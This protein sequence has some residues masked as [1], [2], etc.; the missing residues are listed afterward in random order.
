MQANLQDQSSLLSLAEVDLALSRNRVSTKKLAESTEVDA[1]RGRL[2]GQSDRLIDAR[3][4]LSDLELQ[5]KRSETDLEL[6]EKRLNQDEERLSKAQNQK[7]AEGLQHEIQS[8]KLRKS[9][10]EDVEIGI[11]DELEKQKQL[12]QEI[13]NQKKLAE[14]E[15]EQT[16]LTQKNQEN[17]LG[18]QATELEAKRQQIVSSISPE[19][20][21]AYE[22]KAKRGT[23]FARLMGRDCGACNLSIMA[24]VLD[25]I[26]QLP[27]DQLPECP[28]CQAYLV[29]S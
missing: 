21:L 11:L 10:L 19:L 22:A 29:R 27:L 14:A 25:E 26:S 8:L 13:T 2:L 5:L 4:A 3:N 7:D 17:E 15:L 12:V 16:Q 6:V 9:D 24:T 20:V 18:N 28:S 23:A 1:A